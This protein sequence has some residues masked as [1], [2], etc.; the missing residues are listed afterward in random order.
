MTDRI[1]AITVV[2]ER[3]AREDDV[4]VILNAIRLIRG[5]LSVTPHV[6]QLQD[7]IA[8]ER[9]QHALRAKLREVLWP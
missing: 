7:H 6:A 5:V 8:Q 4:E 3:D 2:L 1:N 9:A